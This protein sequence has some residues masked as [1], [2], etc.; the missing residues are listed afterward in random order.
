MQHENI[1][2]MMMLVTG[3]YGHSAVRDL[4][5]NQLNYALAKHLWDVTDWQRK[6][7]T[8]EDGINEKEIIWEMQIRLFA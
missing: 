5:G 4:P 2:L 1:I 8:K 3:P 6:E 7:S